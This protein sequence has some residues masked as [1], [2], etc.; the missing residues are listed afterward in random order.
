[1]S[2]SNGYNL[3]E[4]LTELTGRLA[5]STDS[6]LNS[7]NKTSASGRY[8]DDG[9]FHAV[10]NVANIKDVVP[11]ASDWNAYFT[12]K[13]NAVITRALQSVFVQPEFKE[14]LFA[15]EAYD[16]EIETEANSGKAVGLKLKLAP[17]FDMAV[18]IKSLVLYF[19]E[20]ATFNVYLFKHGSKT[21]VKTKSVTTEAG[22]RKVI[23]LTDWFINYKEGES[24]YIVYFQD[25]L[26]SAKAIRENTI[27]K[28]AC[29]FGV[30]PFYTDT[31]GIDFDR[32]N[33]NYP[34]EPIGINAIIGS[35]RDFTDNI[36]QQPF[37][38]DELIGLT[39]AYQVIED[40]LYST[41]SNNKER[42][43]KE[44]MFDIG[45]NLDLKGV[46]PISDSP[47]I[48]GLTQRIETEA[49][50]IRKAFY[51]KTKSQVVN[52]DN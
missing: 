43:L 47:K 33:F 9:S 44:Q 17:V 34:S 48:K 31:T 16:E 18:Q 29:H 40:V 36:V 27:C 52:A 4:V 11:T 5:W 14:Q 42:I 12:A 22:N 24:W 46:A 45:L 49:A 41:R 19:D 2:Y 28:S 26:G 15:F 21:A 25:D 8:F 6:T 3:T 30:T 20:A 51:P 35:F 1:M 10:V 37:L 39:M 7:A 13:Q 23:T 50:R 38:F 32:S